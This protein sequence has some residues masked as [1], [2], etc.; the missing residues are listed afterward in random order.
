MSVCEGERGVCRV[1]VCVRAGESVCVGC[2]R[3]CVWG[4]CVCLRVCEACLCERNGAAEQG[5]SLLVCEAHRVP[6]GLG[7]CM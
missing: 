2:V 4:V 7:H 6:Q 1:H 3:E 5:L